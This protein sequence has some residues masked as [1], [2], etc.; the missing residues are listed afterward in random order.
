MMWYRL[1]RKVIQ[2]R[3]CGKPSVSKTCAPC[4]NFWFSGLRSLNSWE[5]S[6]RACVGNCFAKGR[7]HS[8]SLTLSI[9]IAQTPSIIIRVFGP[10]SLKR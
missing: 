1:G 9:K 3:L 8:Q 6:F 5:A 2:E 7:Q 4:A 10:K